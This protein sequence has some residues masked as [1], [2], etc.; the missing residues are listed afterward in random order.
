M[1]KDREFEICCARIAATFAE[2]TAIVKAIKDDFDSEHASDPR[3]TIQMVDSRLKIVSFK[4]DEFIGLKARSKLNWSLQKY[5]TY[6]METL[7]GF[8]WEFDNP[9][10][11]ST[12]WAQKIEELLNILSDERRNLQ[13]MLSHP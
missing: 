8:F 6:A 13:A 4:T 10:L 7:S 5:T 9:F 2:L 12:K 3:L 1:N 11:G